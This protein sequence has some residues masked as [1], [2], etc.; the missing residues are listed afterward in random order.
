MLLEK[1]LNI[2]SKS[3]PY[4][5]S[6]LRKSDDDDDYVLRIKKYLYIQ[7]DIEHD[8]SNA[9]ACS[10]N[11]EIFYLCG[12]S[13]DGKSEILTRCYRKYNQEIIF[14]L[15]ATHSYSQHSS[16]VD[17]LNNLFSK[18]K[19]E[20][21]KL[22]IGINIGMMQKF[23]RFGSSEH[24]DIK[25]NMRSFF[26]NRHVKGYVNE[27]SHFYDFE[28]YPRIVLDNRKIKSSFVS[29]F[30]TRLTAQKLDN[31]FWSAYIEN[32]KNNEQLYKNYKF[33]SI[34][35]VQKKLVELFC[36]IRLY[37]EQFLIPRTFA[38]FIFNILT[39]DNKKT[40]ADNVFTLFDNELSKKMIN[41]DPAKKRNEFLDNFVVEYYIGML[42]NNL[43]S[44]IED[45][46]NNF[47]CGDGVSTII[48]QAFLLH[49]ND[50]YKFLQ[51]SVSE[52]YANNVLDIYLRLHDITFKIDINSNDED[53]YDE[54]VEDIVAKS[55]FMF[56]NRNAISLG[57]EYLSMRDMGD[58]VYV[59]VKTSIT[60]N[61]DLLEKN[62][63]HSIDFI[64]I[65]LNVNDTPLAEFKLDIKLLDFMINIIDGYKPNMQNKGIVIKLEE[66]LNS[67]L[68]AS[69]EAKDLMIVTKEKTEIVSE[70]SRKYIVE[71]I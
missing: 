41:F 4:A 62:K 46:R 65:Y 7:S 61:Y 28:C 6:T 70:K 15:D 33:L 53:W 49:G 58:G 30:I 47:G 2:L 54:F 31:P 23:I 29:E 69:S 55:L 51:K 63:M 9:L 18:Y 44:D 26:Y 16:A 66:L 64:P 32:K 36:L 13:G 43:K 8:F 59:G 71:E 14:H 1:Y 40:L 5:V 34:P 48:R 27:K 57:N 39:L 42:D 11:S 50:K 60:A 10:K 38:D 17:C 56:A 37:E 22:A 67:I 19:C 45:L 20:Q 68:Y 35:N 25:E 12:S 52:G 24:E 3:S 21:F